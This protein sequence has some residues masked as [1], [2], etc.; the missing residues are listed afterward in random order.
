MFFVVTACF[1]I[2][3]SVRAKTNV[4]V[5]Q[6]VVCIL[7][8]SSTLGIIEREITLELITLIMVGDIIIIFLLFTIQV[9]RVN[10]Q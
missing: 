1:L 9:L 6:L 4:K 5:L 3:L 10:K 8:V 2:Y 7:S